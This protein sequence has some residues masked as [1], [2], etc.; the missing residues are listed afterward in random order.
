MQSDV[1][2]QTDPGKRKHALELAERNYTDVQKLPDRKRD[3]LKPD[4]LSTLAWVH[5]R[6][7]EFDEAGT[8]LDLANK[9]AGGWQNASADT[10]AYMAIMYHHNERDWNAKMVLEKI[11]RGN[12]AFSMRPAAFR[13]WD[14]VKDA[15]NP[16]EAAPA[17]KTP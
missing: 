8:I 6:R 14:K 10:A 15:T 16:A 3:A 1:A 4:V 12:R 5:F 7:S 17:A 11:L 2:E 9:A 13:L